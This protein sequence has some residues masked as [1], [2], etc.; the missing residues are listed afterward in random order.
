MLPAGCF[1][2]R[3]VSRA[4]AHTPSMTS[5]DAEMAAEKMIVGYRWDQ[6]MSCDFEVLLHKNQW[7]QVS[8]TR[9]ARPGDE[10]RKRSFSW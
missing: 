10:F 4:S 5:L 8:F 2:D 3:Y 1:A 7:I 9:I 6:S